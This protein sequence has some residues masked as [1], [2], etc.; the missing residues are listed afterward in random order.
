MTRATANAVGLFDNVPEKNMAG[1]FADPLV[2]GIYEDV[3]FADYLA[4]DA[5]SNSKLSLMAKSPR[6]FKLG[7][8]KEPTPSMQL[9][10][11]YHCGVLEPLAFADRYVIQPD[12]HLLPENVTANGAPSESKQTSFVKTK[13]R[14]FREIHVGREA[15]SRQWY[16]QMLSL[17]T[18]L[19]INPEANALLNCDGH[20]EL[21]IVWDEDG[22]LCKARIDKLAYEVAIADLK[23]TL[24]IE[25]FQ[26]TIG[27][28]GYHRQMAHYQRGWEILT[29]DTLPTWLIAVES[30]E[31]NTVQ[32][33]PLH[34]ESLAVG[35]SARRKL[36]D[37]L[38]N[39][40]ETDHW[41]GKPNP[42]H[43][44]VP[45]WAEEEEAI[46]LILD[47]QTIEV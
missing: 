21:S 34:E 3:P 6:H 26:N 37:Q 18:E 14:E 40:L 7:F 45:A 15:V 17:V 35:Y 33:A 32:A 8:F 43:W 42:S 27:R 11:L 2:P 9:G 46:E 20:T 39:C 25:R 31:P 23:S 1:D 22:I 36:M 24:D 10:S 44:H 19:S 12:F 5:V 28:F 29:G 16:K 41:P 38:R 4:W 13:T 30:S 47:G